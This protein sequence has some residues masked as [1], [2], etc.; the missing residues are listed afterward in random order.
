MGWL[1]VYQVHHG[2]SA[3]DDAQEPLP[4]DERASK[5]LTRGSALASP[6]LVP[7]TPIGG[8]R[9]SRRTEALGADW[10]APGFG[11]ESRSWG[12]SVCTPQLHPGPCHRLG[13][14]CA[15]RHV[16]RY[17]GVL[18]CPRC[19]RVRGRHRLRLTCAFSGC[20]GRPGRSTFGSHSAAR[21]QGGQTAD[22]CRNSFH[23]LMAVVSLAK[24]ATTALDARG[25]T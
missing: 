14:K 18:S 2:S 8:S 22:T 17:S 10:T 16:H 24:Y 6:R 19:E 11:A 21:L 20:A 4:D 13:V 15:V 1:H 7:S 23:G 5:V 25:P 3:G 9:S 12:W